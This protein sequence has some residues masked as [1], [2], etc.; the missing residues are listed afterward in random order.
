MATLRKDSRLFKFQ[1][2]NSKCSSKVLL[3]QC[4][5]VNF[6]CSYE[7][8]DATL[9]KTANEQYSYSIVIRRLFDE[10]EEE[11]L[12][13]AQKSGINAKSQFVDPLTFEFNFPICM[14]MNFARHTQG[15][16][17]DREAFKWTDSSSV[18]LLVTL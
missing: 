6:I 15:V 12:S 1:M 17:C 5:F 14:S 7:F 10:D 11:L 9:V 13:A 4:S 18:S 8:A 16:P 2:A 3:L